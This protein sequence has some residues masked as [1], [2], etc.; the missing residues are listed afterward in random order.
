[1]NWYKTSQSNNAPNPAMGGLSQSYINWWS[2]YARSWSFTSEQ[3]A[4][5]WIADRIRNFNAQNK[6]IFKIDPQQDALT[7]AQMP[8]YRSGNKFKI[9]RR[10][11]PKVFSWNDIS[12]RPTSLE[13]LGTAGFIVYEDVEKLGGVQ[14]IPVNSLHGTDSN[15]Q[16][17]DQSFIGCMAQQLR[18]G[19]IP[20][21]KTIVYDE[22]TKGLI[23]GHHRLEAVRIAK[24]RTI[25]A[26]AVRFRDM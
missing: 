25:P 11:R 2:S 20:Y 18:S 21:F 17:K 23:D 3:E 14:L 7:A 6:G 9:G 13:E 22:G 16:Y 24:I 8:L 10:P 4:R 12:I 1:M 26:Q 15:I 19:E 5:Q